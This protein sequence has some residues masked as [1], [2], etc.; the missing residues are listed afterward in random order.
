LWAGTRIQLRYQLL[1]GGE[2]GLCG[3]R[4]PGLQ[5]LTELLELFL[6][7]SLLILHTLAAVIEKTSAG[8]SGY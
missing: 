8:Y 7:L 6:N 5:I 2:I 1:Q 3:G 4:I